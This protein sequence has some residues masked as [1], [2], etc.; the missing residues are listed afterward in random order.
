MSLL[1]A[2]LLTLV[3]LVVD[4]VS[5]GAAALASVLPADLVLLLFGDADFSTLLPDLA[6]FS[7]LPAWLPVDFMVSGLAPLL[8]SLVAS[9]VVSL[10]GN[11]LSLSATF[12]GVLSFI[13]VS[14][15]AAWEASGALSV[16]TSRGCPGLLRD[17]MEMP[18]A[19]CNWDKDILNLPAIRSGF[20]PGCT[21]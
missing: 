1:F 20:S 15:V 10:V 14:E 9:F 5:F 2:E 21:V 13:V 8:F 11:D 7:A 12:T 18:L 6:G 16:M 3:L 19:S 17:F 4:L